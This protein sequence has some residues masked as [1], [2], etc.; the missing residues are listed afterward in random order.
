MPATLSR[1]ALQAANDRLDPHA[2]RVVEYAVMVSRLEAHCDSALGAALAHALEPSADAEE[3]WRRVATGKALET[4]MESGGAPA[5]TDVRDV[6]DALRR[7]ERGGSV[8]GLELYGVAR[9]L[10]AIRLQKDFL[11]D[12]GPEE[13]E[14]E[15]LALVLLPQPRVEDRLDAA[16][17]SDGALRDTAS[18]LLGTLR[19]RKKGAQARIL[20]RIQAYT[21]GKLREALSDPIYTVRQGRYVVPVK[22]ESRGRIKGIVHDTSASGQTVFIE[23][24]DVVEAANALRELEGAEREEESRILKELSSFVGSVALETRQG[25]NC[26]RAARR[27]LRGPAS[28]ATRRGASSP[29]AMRRT[30]SAST[31]GAGA[32]RSSTP[33]RSSRWTSTS[34]PGARSSSPARTPAARPSR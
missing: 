26:P 23:P 2:L 15:T 4:R 29:S 1:P 12:P 21:T 27:A 6:G 3:V 8:G 28:R 5:L 17:E 10:E 32:T 31:S 7:T 24:Q 14:L 16:L 22:S 13:G 18:V 20:E 19:G 33:G 34:L 30:P 9:A 11:G 25:L